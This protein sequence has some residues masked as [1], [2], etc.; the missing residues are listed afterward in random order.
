M[1]IISFMQLEKY[2][3]AKDIMLSGLQIDPLR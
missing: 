2:D 1:I 3:M